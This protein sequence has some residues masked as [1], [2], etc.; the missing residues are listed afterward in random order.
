M[1]YD[2]FK[3]GLARCIDNEKVGFINED[4]EIAIPA[5]FDWASYFENG[6]AKV[7]N[8]CESVSDGEHSQMENGTWGNLDKNGAVTWLDENKAKSRTF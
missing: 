4:L 8:G 5:Q 7:C 6:E 2:Y 1:Y 3:E